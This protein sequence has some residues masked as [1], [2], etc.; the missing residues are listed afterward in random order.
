M[1][2]PAPVVI[3]VD[4]VDLKEPKKREPRPPRE[5]FSIDHET[6]M[7]KKSSEPLE[8]ESLSMRLMNSLKITSTDKLIDVKEENMKAVL[9]IGFEQANQRAH[10]FDLMVPLVYK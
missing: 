2:A 5:R 7:S 4:K 8:F 9:K 6:M 3:P 1:Q 10:L